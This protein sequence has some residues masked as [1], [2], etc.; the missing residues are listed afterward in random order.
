MS[1]NRDLLKKAIDALHHENDPKTPISDYFETFCVSQIFKDNDL[2]YDEVESSILDGT[3]DASIDWALLFVNGGL[4]TQDRMRQRLNQELSIVLHIGQSKYTDGLK[5]NVI[6]RWN[7]RLTQLFSQDPKERKSVT[8]VSETV[9]SYFTSFHK[10][11]DA[12]S[13]KISTCDV[14]LHY[15]TL[16]DV[17]QYKR[18]MSSTIKK[19]ETDLKR[20][21]GHRT[22]TCRFYGASELR[23]LLSKQVRKT[24]TLSLSAPPII[25]DSEDALICL[26][27]INSYFRFLDDGNGS[28]LERLFEANVRDYLGRKG[29]NLDIAKTLQEKKSNADFWWFNNGITIISSKL[30]SSTKRVEIENP[31]IVNGLQTSRSIHEH[32]KSSKFKLKSEKRGIL[33][34]IIRTTDQDLSDKIIRATNNQTPITAL[35]LHSTEKLHK[36]I[37]DLFKSEKW[38]YDRRRNYYK[39]LGVPTTKVVTLK[40]LGQAVMAAAF[41]EPNFAR[42]RPMDKLSDEKSYARIFNPQ[43]NI[44][45]YLRAAQMIREVEAALK[46]MK[47]SRKTRNNIKYYVLRAWSLHFNTSG[48]FGMEQLGK[49]PESSISNRQGLTDC[50]EITLKK[51][52]DLGG[53]DE[54]AKG[55]KLLAS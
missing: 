26:I 48:K 18:K 53:T 24:F 13:G 37:D 20:V 49:I 50:I 11:Y 55:T 21:S 52:N 16:G 9:K 10:F 33:V 39:N 5:E 7:S 3:D 31:L 2:A 44:K 42:A 17:D 8:G 6:D 35:E 12:H 40:E 30:L 46:E 28:V 4:I 51:Y 25:S 45:A 34:K 1:A 23:D 54:L 43:Y 47:E 22:V 36:D 15:A 41:N 14:F 27:P 38:Y 32:F 19:L 29:R